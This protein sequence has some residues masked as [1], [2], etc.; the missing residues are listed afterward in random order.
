MA[1]GSAVGYAVLVYRPAGYSAYTSSGIF[2]ERDMIR[3]RKQFSSLSVIVVIIAILPVFM[4]NNSYGMHLMIMSLIWAVVAASW[5]LVLGYAGIFN[6]G[7]LAF[8][9]IG[10][11]VSS[12]LSV[13]LGLSPWAGLILAGLIS[14]VL[15]VLIGLPCLKLKGIYVA[16]MT[17]AFYEVVGPLII[18]GRP[19]GTGGKGGL[20]PIPAFRIGGYLFNS[21]ELV[22]WLYLALVFF[23]VFMFLI[24][25]MINSTFGVAFTALR[26]NENLA[27]GLGV[28]KFVYSLLLSGAAA[29]ITGIMG[30]FYAH[31]VSMISPRMLGLD[32]FLFLLIMVILGGAGN[33]PGAAIGAFAVTFLNDALRPLDTWRLLV[34][35]ILLVLL[36]MKFPKGIIGTLYDV[37]SNIKERM[38]KSKQVAKDAN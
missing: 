17:L 15:G 4:F 30:A 18:V 27:K 11:Y 38:T 5:D 33:Y 28:N 16:L 8:F 20:F 14:G 2:W 6:L 19:V 24:Y 35:G 1:A 36:I 23:A 31:Y 13:N 34:L 9:A 7:Q 12:M 3:N 32:S 10:A 26:D 29:A 22:P 25:K 37:Y 21:N